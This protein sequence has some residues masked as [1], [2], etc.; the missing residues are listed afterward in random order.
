MS[1]LTDAVHFFC[2]LGVKTL[3]KTIKSLALGA[4]TPSSPVPFRIPVVKKSEFLTTGRAQKQ[5][6]AL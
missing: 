1:R 6:P 4:P 2:F 3:D 5:K